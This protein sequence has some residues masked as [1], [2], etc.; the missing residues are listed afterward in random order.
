MA[1]IKRKMCGGDLDLA[2]DSLAAE[3]GYCGSKQTVPKRGDGTVIAAGSNTFGE[4]DVS[5]WR[6]FDGLEEL[7]RK[8]AAGN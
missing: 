1:V 7:K 8:Y 5:G 4:C 3:C 6:L 2:G